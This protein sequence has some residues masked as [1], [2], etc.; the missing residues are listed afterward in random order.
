MRKS[1][2]LAVIVGCI[3]TGV[4]AAPILHTTDFIAD[5]SRSAFNS[6]EAIPYD[7]GTF[8]TGGAGPYTE[9]G[10]SVEQIG[11]DPGNDIWVTFFRPDGDFGW[12][13]NGGDF[14]YTRITLAGGADFSD[15]GLLYASGFGESTTFYELYNNALLVLAGSLP[16]TPNGSRGANYLGFSGGGFDEIRIYDRNACCGTMNTAAIDAIETA[17]AV[18][19]PAS[20]LLFGA[21]AVAGARRVRRRAVSA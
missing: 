18:P 15:V 21:A 14:G 3:A 17:G 16:G 1:V 4:E 11:G 19:E 13:P 8:F 9:G 2:T 5:G 6:F 10:I 7:G 12:Y 20:L